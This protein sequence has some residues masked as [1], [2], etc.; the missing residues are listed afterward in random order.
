M[1]TNLEHITNVLKVFLTKCKSQTELK[2]NDF[3]VLVSIII[4]I[5]FTLFESINSIFKYTKKQNIL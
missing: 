5:L 4:H 2:L 1:N 3:Y